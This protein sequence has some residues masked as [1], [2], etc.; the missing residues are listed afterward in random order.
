MTEIETA[1]ADEPSKAN[2]PSRKAWWVLL[3]FGLGLGLLVALNMN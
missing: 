3:A 1:H 2:R